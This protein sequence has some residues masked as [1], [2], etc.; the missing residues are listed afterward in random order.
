MRQLAVTKVSRPFYLLLPF[1][2][3]ILVKLF[4]NFWGLKYIYILFI[5]FNLLTQIF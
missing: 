3:L 4:N 2:F 1:F 5:F